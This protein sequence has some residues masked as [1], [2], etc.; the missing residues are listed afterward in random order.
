MIYLDQSASSFPKPE[1]V[2][3]AVLE[4][5]K[6]GGA[7][8]GRSGHALSARAAHCV[9]AAR[10]GLARMFGV[11][12]ARRIL[13]M[14]NATTAINLALHGYLRRGD[15]IVTTSMEHNA[16]MRP[17]RALAQQ[18]ALDV[19]II[20]ADRQGRIDPLALGAA[21]RPDT[22][23]VIVNHASNV[24]GTIA[25]VRA[26]KA[27]IGETTLLVDAAQTAGAVP[28]PVESDRIDLLAFTGHKSLLG[29][30]GTGGL[31]V[32]E[33]LEEDLAPLVY[34]GTGSASESDQQPR[35]LPDY[36]EGGTANGP[37]IAGLGAAIEYL[38]QIGLEEIRTREFALRRMLWEGLVSLPNV[39]LFGPD[40]SVD[41]LPV[42]GLRIDGI[43]PGEL[44]YRLDR[45]H[46]I[47]TRSGL[48]CAPQAHRT[49]GTFPAGTVRL[50]AGWMNR[51][52]DIERAIEAVG[53]IAKMA[54]A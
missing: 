2:V 49:I 34:G 22:R 1:C 25:P 23:L 54:G 42:I 14:P 29:P 5:L 50:S 10:T 12:D 3:A 43:C 52:E 17:L 4:S 39:H 30:Q 40:P 51:T 28:I 15:H 6:S 8:P 18:R 48:Q 44:A 35:G 19:T 24:A 16:V 47:M 7:N 27:A 53:A 45:E 41:A 26:I 38:L 11:C 36:Y 37:G 9:Y 46:G 20:R 31:Y 21:V 32:R 13:L 33:G